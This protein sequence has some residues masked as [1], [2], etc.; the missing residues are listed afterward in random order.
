MGSIIQVESCHD[1][2]MQDSGGGVQFCDFV[3]TMLVFICVTKLAYPYYYWP[4][5][6]RWVG[7]LGH[8]R[9][10]CSVT[11]HLLIMV[12]VVNIWKS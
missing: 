8:L 1:L 6:G 3:G 10:S 4:T 9:K 2:P 7:E 11:R 5:F 12:I